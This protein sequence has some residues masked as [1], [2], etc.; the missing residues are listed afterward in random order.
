MWREEEGLPEASRIPVLTH[1]Y[2][3]GEEL[4]KRAGKMLQCGGKT[5]KRASLL[6][7]R[8]ERLEAVC[9]ADRR[10]STVRGQYVRG[11]RFKASVTS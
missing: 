8:E 5:P 7:Q 3:E 10:P 6:S 9:Q 2:G 1:Q 11:A 4:A